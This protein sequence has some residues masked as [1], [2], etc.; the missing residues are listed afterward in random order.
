M[1]SEKKGYLLTHT[2]PF[3]HTEQTERIMTA[4]QEQW[5]KD[6]NEGKMGRIGYS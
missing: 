4:V 3:E 2:R 6:L 5:A 1:T